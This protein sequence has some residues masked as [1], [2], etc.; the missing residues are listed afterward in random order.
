MTALVRFLSVL[1]QDPQ[2][3]GHLVFGTPAWV[4]GVPSLNT[5]APIVQQVQGTP[6]WI[7]WP[8]P[9]GAFGPVVYSPVSSAHWLRATE[10]QHIH[11]DITSF[12]GFSYSRKNRKKVKSETKESSKTSLKGFLLPQIYRRPHTH[13][14]TTYM[15]KNHFAWN[16]FFPEKK[17]DL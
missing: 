17:V 10:K 11:K 5:W 2:K 6:R 7:R 13:T 9:Q 12:L 1:E 14:H 3:Q 8:S 4:M 15:H 16:P